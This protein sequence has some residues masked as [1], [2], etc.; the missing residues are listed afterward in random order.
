MGPV[1]CENIKMVQD[2]LSLWPSSELNL[3]IALGSIGFFILL[4][5]LFYEKWNEG[6]WTDVMWNKGTWTGAIL[7][8]TSLFGFNILSMSTERTANIFTS[9]QKVELIGEVSDMEIELQDRT[10]QPGTSA[11]YRETVH[12]SGPVSYEIIR[13]DLQMFLGSYKLPAPVPMLIGP[14]HSRFSPRPVDIVWFK[15]DDRLI[16]SDVMTVGFNPGNECDGRKCGLR[17]GDQIRISMNRESFIK[18]DPIIRNL[19]IHGKPY[20]KLEDRDYYSG[21]LRIERCDD[22]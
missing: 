19:D 1:W 15:V 2:E 11:D 5:S 20:R 22:K 18:G 3:I 4:S 14:A 8:S 13:R 12:T 16:K 10:F 9:D 7:I 6:T 17:T 21:T